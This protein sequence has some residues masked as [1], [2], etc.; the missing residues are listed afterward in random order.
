SCAGDGRTPPISAAAASIL[1]IIPWTPE[2]APR[3]TQLVARSFDEITRSRVGTRYTWAR[4]HPP[5]PRAPGA[6][7]APGIRTRGDVQTRGSSPAARRGSRAGEGERRPD[8]GAAEGDLYG[9]PVRPHRSSPLARRP[10]RRQGGGT[11]P[12]GREAAREGR[13]RV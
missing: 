5:C 7:D 4:A 9:R 3:I 2:R 12:G 10:S 1:S 13:L 6:G 11:P 8:G